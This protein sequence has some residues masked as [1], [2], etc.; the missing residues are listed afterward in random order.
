MAV[1]LGEAVYA[2]LAAVTGVT[3]LVGTRI[4]G[5]QAP[6]NPTAPYVVYQE[7]SQHRP[8]AMGAD[9]GK[10]RARVQVDSR[11]VTYKGAKQLANAVQVALQ[12]YSGTSASIEVSAVFLDDDSGE[13]SYEEEVEMYRVRQTYLIWHGE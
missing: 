5:G 9:V 2:R 4:Y 3:D 11:A 12:R 7:I 1:I 8:S 13:D 10:V 6:Q